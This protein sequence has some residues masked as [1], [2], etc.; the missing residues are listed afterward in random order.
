[1]TIRV[2]S[3]ELI[4][5][6]EVYTEDTQA[7]VELRGPGQAGGVFQDLGR[8]PVTVVMSGILF[9]EESGAALEELR[10]AQQKARP[11][12][13][14]AEV[15]AGAEFTDVMI[16]DLRVRQ[17]AGARGRYSFFLRVREHTEAPEPEDAGVAEV[18]AAIEADADA[19]SGGATDAASVLEDASSLA[20]A[21]AANPAL[22]DNLSET[23]LAEVL[24]AATPGSSGDALGGVLVTLGERD[25]A[26]L[27]AAL[28]GV[29]KNGGLSA[30]I[31]KVSAASAIVRARLARLDLASMLPIVMDMV[32]GAG[33]IADLK[34]VMSTAEA[35][36]TELR[37]FDP[38][39][40]FGDIDREVEP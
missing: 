29:H 34:R 23:E 39:T 31:D 12:P 37:D 32:K 40:I 19:W 21:T 35:L 10:Q 13:F 38:D 25:P 6:Q 3:I 36:A 8:E 20:E 9:G 18:E 30:L 27:G 7:L 15:I 26:A 16:L 24:G 17:L 11:L 1:M 2:G 14:A 22:L 5:L 33:I 4:G 28:T